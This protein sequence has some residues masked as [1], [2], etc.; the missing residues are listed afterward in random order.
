MTNNSDNA[1]R[2]YVRNVNQFYLFLRSLARTRNPKNPDHKYF[3]VSPVG[4]VDVLG[5]CGVCVCVRERERERKRE[6]ACVDD[7]HLLLCD[8]F[9]CLFSIFDVIDCFVVQFSLN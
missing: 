1:L 6:C 3:S 8:F 5:E 4:D 7:L 9:S 2:T